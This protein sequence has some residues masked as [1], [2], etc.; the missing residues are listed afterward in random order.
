MVTKVSYNTVCVGKDEVLKIVRIFPL[1]PSIDK[2]FAIDEW[3]LQKKAF[4]EGSLSRSG[5][6]ISLVRLYFQMS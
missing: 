4:F 3:N 1:K 2:G 5:S 6:E